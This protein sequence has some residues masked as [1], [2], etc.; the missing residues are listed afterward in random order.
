MIF[1]LTGE[2]GS[3]KTTLLRKVADELKLRGVKID[4]FLSDRILDG[5]ETVGYDLFDLKKRTRLPFLRKNGRAGWQKVGPYVILPAGLAEAGK[6]INRSG[7]DDLL[8]IDEAGPLEL[9]GKGCWPALSPKI[10]DP[11]QR[12]FLVIRKNILEKFL[13]IL[14]YAPVE[15]YET[16]EADLSRI[17]E[18]VKHHVR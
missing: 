3:G 13:K 17:V 11:S 9:E 16:H 10:L 5:E 2:V 4:G 18:S 14:V 7:N 1:I 12:C 15:I 8:F 6:I